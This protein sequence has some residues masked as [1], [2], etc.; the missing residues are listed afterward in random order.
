MDRIER[1]DIDNFMSMFVAVS[2]LQEQRFFNIESV[3][4]YLQTFY[5]I[6]DDMVDQI[7]KIAIK[8]EEA[9]MLEKV[10]NYD[11]LYKISK[12]IPFKEIVFSNQ[13]YLPEMVNFFYNFNNFP[14][15]NVKFIS[16]QNDV[17]KK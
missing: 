10:P 16:E 13:E 14:I 4:N 11:S 5:Q 15:S 2:F 17:I 7:N 3:K 1:I 12:R 9:K 6:D 8:M